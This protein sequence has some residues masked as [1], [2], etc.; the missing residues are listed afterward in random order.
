MVRKVKD[1]ISSVFCRGLVVGGMLFLL[2]GCGG[3][4]EESGTAAVSRPSAVAPT[5]SITSGRVARSA[6]APKASNSAARQATLSWM[7]PS[8]RADGTGLSRQHLASYEIRYGT[9]AD[10]LN[11]LAVF[12]RAAGLIDMSYTIENLSD[13][14]WY[15]TIQARDDNGLL[16]SPSEVVSKTIPS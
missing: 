3:D 15:F 5:A 9:N 1:L 10:D 14:T 12:D 7:A 8:S 13:G 11:R 6:A 16:S 2:A 4:E